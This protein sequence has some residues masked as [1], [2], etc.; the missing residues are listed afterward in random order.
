MKLVLASGSPRRRELL[1]ELNYDYSVFTAGFDESTVKF[2]S[3]SEGVMLLAEGKA[4][5]AM[6]TYEGDRSETLFLGSDTVVTID[7]KILGKPGSPEE[8]K[9]MLESLSGRTHR[10]YT[11]VSLVTEKG[12]EN[13][14]SCTSVTFRTLTEEEI[15]EYVRSGEPMD[16][17]GAYGIQG[18][19]KLLV[20]KIYGDYYTVV[21]LPVAAVYEHLKKYHIYPF[22]KQYDVEV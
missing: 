15:I 17:A 18:L 6:D 16:K 1:S 2:E 3:P 8:A 12:S 4:R 19:G 10:V 22:F 5:A 7:G 21:G 11:G 13:F 14:F 9:E 20:E